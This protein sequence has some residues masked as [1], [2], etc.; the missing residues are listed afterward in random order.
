MS[1]HNAGVPIPKEAA[2]KIF[3]ALTRVQVGDTGEHNADS[4]NLGLG[5]YITKQILVAHGGTIAVVSDESGTV[6][7]ATLPRYEP[8]VSG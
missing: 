6:F 4:Q 7:T 2:G 8:T 3:D 5:L 1:V